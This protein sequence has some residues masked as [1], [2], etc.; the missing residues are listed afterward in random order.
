M[1]SETEESGLNGRLL[2][3]MPHM[4]DARF[5]RS[6]VYVCFH[7]REGAFGLV[8][9][10][11]MEQLTFPKLLR[12]LSITPSRDAVLKQPILLGGPV[13]TGRGFVLHTS[14][15]SSESATLRITEEISLTGTS[16]ALVAMTAPEPP[17]HALFALGYAGW[18]AGQLESEL[19]DNGWLY[20]DA[21]TDLVFDLDLKGKYDRA[22]NQLGLDI[23]D[24]SSVSGSA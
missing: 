8:I 10:K 7:N 9:N 12:Q 2:I 18:G 14:D 23:T 3:A 16:D 21:D 20:G 6:L 1:S 5:R 11:P 15:Y 24:L 19:Q 22:L 4:Q 13:E 17:R